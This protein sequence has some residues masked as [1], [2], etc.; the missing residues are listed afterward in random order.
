MLLSCDAQLE[1]ESLRTLCY[2]NT[3]VFLVCFSLVRIS[4]FDAVATRWLPEVRRLC[5]STPVVLVG[6]QC[7]RRLGLSG[8]GVVVSDERAAVLADRVGAVTYLPCSATL[9]LGIKDVFDVAIA[10]S[11]QQRGLVAGSSTGGCSGSPYRRA[12]SDLLRR[13][14]L[15]AIA[16]YSRTTDARLGAQ[17]LQAVRSNGSKQRRWKRLLC[18]FSE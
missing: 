10:V 3:D 12:V 1:L 13:R 16:T 4:S 14:S 6:T 5:P 11:L 15:D 9:P 17:Q 2:D 7:D 18:C 8:R